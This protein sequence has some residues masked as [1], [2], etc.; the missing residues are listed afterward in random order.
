MI[1]YKMTSRISLFIFTF[2]MFLVVSCTEKIDIQLDDSYTRLVVDGSITTDTMAHKVVL[3]STSSYYY[4][5]AALPVTGALLTISDGSQDFNLSETLPGVYSTAPDVHGIPGKTY[6]LN[7]KLKSAI[8]GYD[9][10]LVSSTLYPVAPLDS[11]SLL[12]H[13]DW[14]TDG[15]WEV[16]CYEQEPPTIDFYRFLVSKNAQVI[17]DTMNEWIIKNDHLYNGN[18]TNGLPVGYINQGNSWEKVAE[19]DI[20]GVEI[21][22]IGKAYFDFIQTAQAELQGSNPLFGGPPANI[23]GNINNGGFGFFSAYSIARS[24]TIVPAIKK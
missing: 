13:S 2:L 10:Y 17:T 6:K 5:Q 3:S 16:K 20:V 4:S 21:N 23:K 24:R 14:S 19:G 7:I 12:F 11:I 22:G 9:E 8:G 1:Q 18:N 15:V